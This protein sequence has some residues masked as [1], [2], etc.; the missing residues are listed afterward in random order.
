MGIGGCSPGVKR[1]GCETDNTPLSAAQVKND[2]SYTSTHTCRHE[3]YRDLSFIPSKFILHSNELLLIGF[4]VLYNNI[5]GT[6]VAQ[7]L[8]CCATNRK[9]AGSIPA[10]VIEFFVD[11]ILP[12]AL[13]PWGRLSL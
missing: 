12:I 11:K 6:A 5:T 8:R 3:K 2:R 7:W 4:I 9:V 1:L 13:W 10:G